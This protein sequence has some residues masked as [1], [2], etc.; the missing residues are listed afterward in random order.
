MFSIEYKYF[1]QAALDKS[2]R[3]AADNLCI[4]SSAVVRQIHKL[5][6]NLI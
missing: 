1:H 5:E 2:I 6:D 3:K 4:N